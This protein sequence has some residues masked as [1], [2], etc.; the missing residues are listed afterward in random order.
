MYKTFVSSYQP[1]NF[2]T[3]V[4]LNKSLHSID[5]K[6][7]RLKRQDMVK[8]S[9][10]LVFERVLNQYTLTLCA[11]LLIFFVGKFVILTFPS[12]VSQMQFIGMCTQCL[13]YICKYFFYLWIPADFLFTW[14][15]M[16]NANIKVVISSD[17]LRNQNQGPFQRDILSVYFLD[18]T[19]KRN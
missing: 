6:N 7:L 15:I 16:R 2:I 18:F 5:K 14:K 1:Y 12:Y 8:D 10:I 13:E 19:T 17:R 11:F 4:S 9:S 3:I